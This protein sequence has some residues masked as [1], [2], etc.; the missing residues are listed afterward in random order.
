MATLTATRAAAGFPVFS[1]VGSGALAC[2][3]GTY[4]VTALSNGDIIE[5]CKI[6][7]GAKVV[8]GM[9]YGDDID[10]GTE[11]L[12]IDVGYAA[13]GVESADPDAFGNLGVITGDA[14]TGLK[15]EVGIC[16][17]FFGT[18]KDGPVE[19][20]A[21]TTIQLT[22]NADAHTGDAGTISVVVYYIVD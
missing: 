4:E 18:L 12:D 9:L 19:L 13:N 17:P 7:A 22:V 11:E 20:S 15:P 16:Y 1:P 6:P 14:V 5:L 3:Y 21:E 10:T 2:A 8:G